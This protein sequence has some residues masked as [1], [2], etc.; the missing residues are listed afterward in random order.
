M[1][2]DRKGEGPATG[3]ARAEILNAELALGKSTLY[4][5]KVTSS[6]IGTVH[7]SSTPRTPPEAAKS[8]IVLQGNDVSVRCKEAA[9]VPVVVPAVVPAVEFTTTIYSA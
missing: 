8:A 6:F 5:S 7:A 2:L 1:M 9:L 3:P 4:H